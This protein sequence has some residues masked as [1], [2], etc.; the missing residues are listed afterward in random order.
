MTNGGKRIMEFTDGPI[1]RIRQH[2]PTGGLTEPA[3]GITGKQSLLRRG[4]TRLLMCNRAVTRRKLQQ[5]A[6]RPA[7]QADPDTNQNKDNQP[8]PTRHAAIV[9][10]VCSTRNIVS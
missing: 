4:H 2:N 3:A 10:Q 7:E 8:S 9:V 6:K 1:A 5:T